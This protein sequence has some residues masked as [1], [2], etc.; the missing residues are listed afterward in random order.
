MIDENGNSHEC[1]ARGRFRKDQKKPLVGDCVL[2]LP[3]E[4][5]TGTGT[6]EEIKNRKNEL[7]RPASANIDQVLLV[8]SVANPK[9]NFDLLD[10][11]LIM[12][13]EKKLPVVLCFNKSDLSEEKDR[14]EI[15]NIFRSTGYPIYFI[16]VKE[17]IGLDELRTALLHQ[18]T[19]LAGT[20]G[21]GKSSLLNLLCGRSEMETGELS[22]KIERGKNT[23][24]HS[25][26]FCIEPGTYVM[27][28]PGF[29]SITCYDIPANKLFL[30]YPEMIEPEKQCRFTGCC[31]MEEPDCGVK[32]A[33]LNGSISQ[34]R[35][36]N[37]RLIYSELTKRKRY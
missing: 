33:V 6:I 20:S 19:V 30:Y 4:E 18:T 15:K 36:E 16:S 34:K 12:M 8:F 7:V 21:V 26:L 2:F 31:H 25:E 28:T 10:R 1:K 29:S 3:A 27:D 9:P 35:Y 22:R 32:A 37:Y 17:N 13:G 14:E 23:T 24:R 11:F 5:T